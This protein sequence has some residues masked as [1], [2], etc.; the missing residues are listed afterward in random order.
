MTEKK[1]LKKGEN[2]NY[3]SV[4]DQQLL[5]KLLAK[6]PYDPDESD[7]LRYERIT[8]NIPGKTSRQVLSYCGSSYLTYSIVGSIKMH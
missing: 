3:W 7:A 5:E 2:W 6:Y 1:G 8:M 4:E